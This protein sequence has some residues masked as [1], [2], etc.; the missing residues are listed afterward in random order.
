MER[1]KMSEEFRI[2]RD[3]MGE[4]RVPA[5]AL[6]AAQTQRAVE[7]FPISGQRFGR[8][9]IEALGIVKQAAALTNGDLGNLDP[10]IADAIASAAAE[11]AS[12]DWDG[13]FVIDVYQTG[14]GTSTNMNAN[15]VI[16]H[17][18]KRILGGAS[19]H[20][21]DEVNFGQSSNDVIPTAIH[22]AARVA[23]ER[24]LLPALEELRDALS[25]KARE[26]DQVVKSGRTHLM[27]ATPVRLGQEFSGYASQLEHG[28]ARVMHASEELAELALGGTATGTGI[29]THTDFS[30]LTI[31]RI[32]KETGLL[33]REA[34]NHFEAQGARDSLV[35][36]HG[37]LNTVAVSLMKIA[38]DIRWLASGPTSGIAEIFLP[39]I[40]PGSSIMPGKVNP[41]LSEALMMV[42]A[43]VAGNQT[44]MTVAGGR[45][46]FE[47]NVMMPVMAQTFLESVAILA[48]AVRAFTAKC[49]RGIRA[50]ESR[51]R[52]L[53]EKNPAIATALNLKIGYDR[54][55][56]VAKQSAKEGRSVRDIVLELGLLTP[57]EVD[58]ALDVR[59]MTEPGFPGGGGG[60]GGG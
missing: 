8:R 58:A 19:V 4:M 43:R 30:R 16:A 49:V 9:M 2:E 41:V 56:E 35:Q 50:N 21:N 38:D 15:E 24:D 44:T 22:V 18:A 36:A 52:E 45:G 28:I 14:S 53:L 10:K 42:A 13:E 7:N 26:L 51:A 23:L 11:V 25:E 1:A 12:G 29:N 39:A 54:A 32:S 17:L 55:A 59:D 46:N 34:S 37:S 48:G 3:S 33:F 27:D 47:L 57:E 40:Q 60:G 5:S 20:P 6:Y 31:E